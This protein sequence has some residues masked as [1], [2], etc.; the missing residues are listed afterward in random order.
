VAKASEQPLFSPIVDFEILAGPHESALVRAPEVDTANP[1]HMA[2]AARA[3]A[4]SARCVVVQGRYEHVSFILQPD[5]VRIRVLD[6]I[7]PEPAKLLDQA[8]RVLEVAD[9]LPPVELEPELI[10]L[11]EIARAHPAE[12]YL[13]PCRVS[14]VVLDEGAVDYLDQ[15]PAYRQWTLVGCA[16]SREIY[17]WFYKEEPHYL[18]M[19]PRALL[20][21]GHVPTLT[22]CC[23]LENR[24]RHEGLVV[25]V[26]WGA[27]LDEVRQGLEQLLH[28]VEPARPGRA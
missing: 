1:T 3:L 14:G 28:T 11:R 20:H 8:C 12:R 10:D 23:Q 24:I 18:E 27:T 7:P 26:P 17:R 22:K 13:F 25:T 16:R 6:V 2:R 4:P 5:P 9:E 19:C 15:R 21:N